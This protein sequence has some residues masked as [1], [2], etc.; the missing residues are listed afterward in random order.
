MPRTLVSNTRFIS[1]VSRVST[2]WQL[3]CLVQIGYFKAKQAFFR[4]ALEDVP[5]EDV[6]FM[7]QRYFPGVSLAPRPWPVK[8]FVVKAAVAA[9]DFKKLRLWSFGIKLSEPL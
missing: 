4:F 2:Q 1:K 6:A 5:A 3:Y 9:A 8:M 7:M